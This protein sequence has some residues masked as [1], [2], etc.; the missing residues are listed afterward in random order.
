[1]TRISLQIV[2]FFAQKILAEKCVP[3]KLQ[4]AN[5][6]LPCSYPSQPVL[7]L[8]WFY[9]PQINSAHFNMKPGLM[10]HF[11]SAPSQR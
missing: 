2:F 3:C 5:I 10:E 1:M 9:Y 8:S 7:I 6:M 11:L 4:I